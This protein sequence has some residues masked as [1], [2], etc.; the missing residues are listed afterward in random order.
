MKEK[1]KRTMLLVVSACL[2]LADWHCHH[3]DDSP[4]ADSAEYY[5]EETKG[6]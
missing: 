4:Q 3:F 5:V 1:K 6:L 2:I